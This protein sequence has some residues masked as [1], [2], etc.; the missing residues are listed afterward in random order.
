M[1]T[2]LADT[3]FAVD[4]GFKI[5]NVSMEERLLQSA[6][7]T[8]TNDTYSQIQDLINN[9]VRYFFVLDYSI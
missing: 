4:L 1:L 5:T 2:E 3:S 9:L 7:L 6:R 8:F